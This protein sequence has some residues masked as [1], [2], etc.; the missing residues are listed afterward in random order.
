MADLTM[1]LHYDKTP[2]IQSRGA[3]TT[4]RAASSM[5]KLVTAIDRS[6][7]KGKKRVL[8]DVN[9]YSFS[10]HAVIEFTAVGAGNF[11]AIREHLAAVPI[12]AEGRMEV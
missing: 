9:I 2:P 8:W 1:T 11:R 3:A 7:N 12:G 4:L 10:D 5:L 6:V